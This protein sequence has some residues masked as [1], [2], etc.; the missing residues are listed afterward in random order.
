MSKDERK[1]ERPNE[2]SNIDKD[3]IEFNRQNKK[4]QGLKILTKIICLLDYQFL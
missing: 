4:G 1:I 3:I 2:I